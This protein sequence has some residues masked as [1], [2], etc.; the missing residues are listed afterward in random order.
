M[1]RAA[2]N[3]MRKYL[4]CGSP[5]TRS[6]LQNTRR[7][8]I[9]ERSPFDE[10]VKVRALFIAS[11]LAVAAFAFARAGHADQSPLTLPRLSSRTQRQRRFRLIQAD[12][13]VHDFVWPCAAQPQSRR[14]H[15]G[16]SYL[17]QKPFIP[18]QRRGTRFSQIN[19]QSRGGQGYFGLANQPCGGCCH[20]EFAA[21]RAKWSRRL[22]LARPILSRSRRQWLADKVAG[23]LG[24]MQ[25]NGPVIMPAPG[26]ALS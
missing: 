14:D 23:Y 25:S 12:A 6:S 11:L 1:L 9:C 4:T 19:H 24:E 7:N 13:V 5:K 8:D 21:S 15:I 3:R 17:E 2:A 22:R 26:K 16:G 18:D 20:H 10:T